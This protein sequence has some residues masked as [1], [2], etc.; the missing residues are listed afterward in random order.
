[1]Y[2]FITK[3][4]RILRLVKPWY[5]TDVNRPLLQLLLPQPL[6]NPVGGSIAYVIQATQ[7]GPQTLPERIRKDAKGK[8]SSKF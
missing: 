3:E 6:V 2:F 1:M 7:A 8:M 4:E 5:S